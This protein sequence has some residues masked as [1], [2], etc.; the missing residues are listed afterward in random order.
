MELL[1]FPRAGEKIFHE[2]LENGL[3]VFVFP[4]PEFQKSYAFSPPATAAR[5]PVSA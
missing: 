5:T 3:N 2:V 1:Q 4:K